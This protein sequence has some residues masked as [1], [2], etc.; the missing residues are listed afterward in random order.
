MPWSCPRAI[1]AAEEASVLRAEVAALEAVPVNTRAATVGLA[2]ALRGHAWQVDGLMAYMGGLQAGWV[3]SGW[4][5][6]DP[7]LVA[8]CV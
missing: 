6:V 3:H 8:S 1:Q 4:D 5:P 7:A 2:V